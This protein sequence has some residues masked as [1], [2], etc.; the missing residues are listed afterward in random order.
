MFL[1]RTERRSIITK[2][3]SSRWPGPPLAL[4]SIFWER[5][6]EEVHTLRPFVLNRVDNENFVKIDFIFYLKLIHFQ[7]FEIQIVRTFKILLFMIW[8][9]LIWFIKYLLNLLQNSTGFVEYKTLYNL[10]LLKEW[11]QNQIPNLVIF[12]LKMSSIKSNI[13]SLISVEN[14]FHQSNLSLKTYKISI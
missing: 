6:H 11:D 5:S 2:F 14:I 13:M 3:L 10:L 12:A 8:E 7:A 1:G 9:I 4:S